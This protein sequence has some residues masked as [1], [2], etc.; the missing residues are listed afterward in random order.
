MKFYDYHYAPSPRRVRMFT[1]EK[2][3]DIPVVEV[4]LRNRA[5]HEHAFQQKNPRCTVPV[6]E[7]D[8]GELIWETLAIC[9]YLEARY[10]DPPL[11]GSGPEQRA[12]IIMW[13]QRII[14]DGFMAVSESYRNFVK[15]FKGRA[16]TGPVG[17]DQ[18]PE[19]VERGR[20]RAKVFFD[21]LDQHLAGREFIVDDVF[22]LADIAAVA[23]VD[24]A[25]AIKLEIEDDQDDLR[26]WHQSV[27]AR[28]S[29]KL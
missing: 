5:Q 17:Y 28:P 13:Y 18:I 3:L 25:K 27:S 10:P 22:T 1:H 6:L 29:A 7:L 11:I 14:D 23:T 15:G 4:D 12:R 19:L 24:F 9:E 16:L 20:A 2:G 26:R 21:D 8:D